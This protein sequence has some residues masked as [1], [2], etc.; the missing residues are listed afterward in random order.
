M[1]WG[2]GRDLITTEGN[3]ERCG[4]ALTQRLTGSHC[5]N[6][7]WP[8][9]VEQS[10]KLIPPTGSPRKRVYNAETG[11]YYPEAH[12]RPESLTDVFPECEDSV[13]ETRSLTDVFPEIREKAPADPASAGTPL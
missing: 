1:T 3:C 8:G 11:I 9:Y 13:F 5:R 10:V 7:G 12:R 4:T 6:C 2:K